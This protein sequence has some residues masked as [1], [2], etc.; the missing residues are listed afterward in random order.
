MNICYKSRIYQILTKIENIGFKMFVFKQSSFLNLRNK[1]LA[2]KRNG[3][4]FGAAISEYL[5]LFIL[6]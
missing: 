3:Y 6:L 4:P 1:S 5:E 2:L